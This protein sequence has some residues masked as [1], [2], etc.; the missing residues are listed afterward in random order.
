MSPSISRRDFLKLTG[1]AQLGVTSPRLARALRGLRAPA[2]NAKNVLVLVFDALCGLNLSYEGYARET[3]PNLARLAKRAIVYHNH[4]A[5]S[6]F[7]TSGT[8]SLLTGTLPWT[9]RAIEDDGTVADALVEHNLFRSFPDYYRTAFTHNS[10]AMALLDQFGRAIDDLVP[11]DKVYLQTYDGLIHSLFYRDD[12]IADVSWTRD[13]KL[14]GGYAYSLFLSRLYKSF[15][16][17]STASLEASFPRG[18]PMNASSDAF[19]ME[20]TVSWLEDHLKTLPQPFLGYYHFLPPH[21]PYRTSLEFYGRFASDGLNPVHKPLDEFG[22]KEAAQAALEARTEY[23]EFILYADKAFGS[24]YDALQR[25]GLLEN[26]WLVV[27][28]DHGEMFERGLIGHGNS[29]L[30]QPVIRIPL[31]ILEPGRETGTDIHAPTSAVD[32]LPTLAQVTGHPIPDWTEGMVLPPY[33][34]GNPDPNRPIYALEARRSS[35]VLAPVAG[36]GDAGEGA[37]QDNLLLRIR[38][39]WH[40]RRGQNV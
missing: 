13:I 5:G 21:A 7:T 24:M 31:L 38:A 37:V 2:G 17:A 39:A 9:H 33:S 30:Y 34:G 8:A 1:L 27:T 10:W 11:R 26:T 14:Q 32:V 3:A 22:T 19:L 6:N 25:S 28:S 20:Q 4:F 16:D 35:P 12:D 40:A 29:T 15:R 36:H 18:L 23:D